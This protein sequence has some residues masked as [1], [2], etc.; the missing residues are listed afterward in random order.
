MLTLLLIL[1]EGFFEAICGLA[2]IYN[3]THSAIR[4]WLASTP[5]IM[6]IR[7]DAAEVCVDVTV[8]TF[9]STYT[10]VIV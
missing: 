2:E 7:A 5:V 3:K 10:I 9:N 8:Y 4:F 1:S 6:F